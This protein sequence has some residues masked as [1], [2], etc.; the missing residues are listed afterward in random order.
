MFRVGLNS[1]VIEQYIVSGF[2]VVVVVGPNTNIE[3]RRFP[4]LRFEL[5]RGNCLQHGTCTVFALDDSVSDVPFGVL[6][7]DSGRIAIGPM[8]SDPS[9]VLFADFSN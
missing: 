9:D 7:L 2:S 4:T 6:S 1:Y 5:T 8:L 3:H